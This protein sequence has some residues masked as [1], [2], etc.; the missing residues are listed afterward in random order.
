MFVAGSRAT[1]TRKVVLAGATIALAFSTSSALAQNCVTTQTGFNITNIGL[2]AVPAG[3]ASAAI[4]GAVGSVNSIFLTQQGSAFVSAPG[5]PAHF[6][7]ET[8]PPGTESSAAETG[9]RKSALH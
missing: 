3:A 6:P 5:N 2:L 4:A 8:S 9:S 7:Y 1:Q